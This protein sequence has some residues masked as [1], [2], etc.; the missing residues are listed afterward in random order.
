[1]DH[2]DSARIYYAPVRGSS[3]CRIGD[4]DM[5]TGCDQDEAAGARRICTERWEDDRAVEFIPWNDRDREDDMAGRRCSRSIPWSGP[6]ADG[7][8]ANL[9]CIPDGV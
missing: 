9:G 8:P 7:L 4:C 6:D 1:M 3:R 2:A 5:S